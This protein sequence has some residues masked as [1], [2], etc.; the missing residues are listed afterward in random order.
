MFRVALSLPNRSVTLSRADAE[1][2][3]ERRGLRKKLRENKDGNSITTESGIHLRNVRY[4]PSA[5]RSNPRVFC[6]VQLE[7]SLPYII[8]GDHVDVGGL[9]S[10]TVF[11][12][13]TVRRLLIAEAVVVVVVVELIPPTP[14]PPPWTAQTLFLGRGLEGTW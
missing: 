7:S 5:W 2:E 6:L 1:A 12:S 14:P 3:A 11:T 8:P 13:A 9:D 4:H 10:S